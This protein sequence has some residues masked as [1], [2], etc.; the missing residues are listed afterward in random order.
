[1]KISVIGAAGCIGS[2]IAFNIIV[3]KLA[4]EMIVADIR[5]D[6]LEH[7]CIDFLDAAVARDIDLDV[8]TGGHEDIRNSDIV[9]QAAGTSVV[10]KAAADKWNLTTRQRMLPENLE[11]VKEWTK[12]INEYC[13]QAIVITA[14]N[15]AEVLNYATYLLSSSRERGRFI[16]YSLNDTTRFRIAIS[17]IKG[18]APSRINAMVAGEHGGSMVSLFSSV[19]IDGKAVEFSEDEKTKILEITNDYLPTML[20]LN[21]PRTSGWLTGVGVAKIVNAI[22]NDTK[23]VIPACTVLDGEYGYKGTSIGLPLKIGRQ[24]ISEITEIEMNPQEKELLD[25]SVKNIR[26]SVDYV[27]AN[28]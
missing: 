20:R 25:D 13:P 8:R 5:E 9:I 3:R 1:M 28:I 10:N 23:E 16:G 21:L 11:I 2:S 27:L 4:D 7:H 22:V 6:W 14:T 15:P 24:G 18:A 19:R 12:A 17:R 26:K